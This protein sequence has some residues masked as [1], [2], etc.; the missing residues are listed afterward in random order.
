MFKMTT[1][2]HSKS[3]ICLCL[4]HQSANLDDQNVQYEVF[5]DAELIGR[6]FAL[7]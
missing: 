1:G 5:Q 4:L 6:D 3:P 7:T 2:S